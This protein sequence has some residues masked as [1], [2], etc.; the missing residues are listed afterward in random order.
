MIPIHT[1]KLKKN[2]CIAWNLFNYPFHVNIVI[3][4]FV[5]WHMHTQRNF[6]DKN[7]FKK[8]DTQCHIYTFVLWTPIIVVNDHLS[9]TKSSLV[10]SFYQH[11]FKTLLFILACSRM[12]NCWEKLS[13]CGCVSA[14]IFKWCWRPPVRQHTLS[15][16]FCLPLC[17]IYLIIKIL[18][19]LLQNCNKHTLDCSTSDR[20]LNKLKPLLLASRHALH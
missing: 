18:Y 16:S 2:V 12:R 3:Y 1:H 8:S 17:L 4:A 11:K 19:L 10:L 13:C 14:V 7:T 5:H 20:S 6:L 9:C 15:L